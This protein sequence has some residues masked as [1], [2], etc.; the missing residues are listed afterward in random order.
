MHMLQINSLFW[1]WCL[2]SV[3]HYALGTVLYSTYKPLLMTKWLSVLLF[4]FV[5]RTQTV[6][7]AQADAEKIKVR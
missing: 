2:F 4:T 6:F 7:K 5:F 1:P 3:L